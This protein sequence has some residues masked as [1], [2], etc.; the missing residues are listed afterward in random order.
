MNRAPY[1]FALLLL[2]LLIVVVI[3]SGSPSDCGNAKVVRGK[4]SVPRVDSYYI[5]LPQRMK[6]KSDSFNVTKEGFGG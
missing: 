1:I 3:L 6:E 5:K 2:A 4:D